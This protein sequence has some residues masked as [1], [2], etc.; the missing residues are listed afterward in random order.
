M[1]P[2]WPKTRRQNRRPDEEGIKTC[3]SLIFSILPRQNRR[4]DEE[5]IKTLSFL[6]TK[7]S[8]SSQNRRP[9]EEGIKTSISPFGWY[10]GQVRT[11]DLMKKGLRPCS[12]VD[13][14]QSFRQNRRPDEEGIKTPY[15]PNYVVCL[16]QNR[17]PDE[18]GIKTA[19]GL[20]VYDPNVRTVDLMKK[21]LR[22]RISR[23]LSKPGVHRTADL[24]TILSFSP[25]R[26]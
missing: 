24:M 11:V 7:F 17:R 12:D 5:G 15:R 20:N 18:E 8:I 22:R 16:R 25:S 9:D 10:P 26:R 1:Q 6:S 19:A 4:P 13:V 21:G 2:V 3:T 14:N 23:G